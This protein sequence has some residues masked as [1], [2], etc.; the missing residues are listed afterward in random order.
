VSHRPGNEVGF[1]GGNF[2]FTDTVNVDVH[3]R[4]FSN[5]GPQG[6]LN[7]ER[8][9]QSV[10]TRTEV[11]GGG[12][13]TNADAASHSDGSTHFEAPNPKTSAIWAESIGTLVG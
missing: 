4:A 10:K 2:A 3:A 11:G 7:R 12:G 9:A 6:V 5:G 1:I 13:N 8:H